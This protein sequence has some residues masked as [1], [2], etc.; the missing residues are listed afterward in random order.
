MDFNTPEELRDFM[1]KELGWSP[2]VSRK[3]SYIEG[4][5]VI[6]DLQIS[7]GPSIET[8]IDKKIEALQSGDMHKARICQEIY[9]N[10]CG[11]SKYSGAYSARQETLV[12]DASEKVLAQLNNKLN[13]TSILKEKEQKE[14]LEECKDFIATVDGITVP[15]I[16]GVE[17]FKNKVNQ[18]EELLPKEEQQHQQSQSINISKEETNIPPKT[19]E[20]THTSPETEQTPD[21]QK[22]FN[23]P[24]NIDTT[25][26]TVEMVTFEKAYGNSKGRLQQL[27]AKF[28]NFI[29]SKMQTQLKHKHNKERG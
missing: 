1:E 9:Y 4:T 18:L 13:N 16:S 6:G 20:Q 12:K 17:A 7:Y 14:L 22:I 28:K 25:S 10:Y 24:Q 8:L 26:R 19:T 5:L 2:S 29:A 3:E 21:M 15:S 27:F 11:V 23:D